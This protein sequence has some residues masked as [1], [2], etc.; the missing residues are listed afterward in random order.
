MYYYEHDSFFFGNYARSDHPTRCMSSQARTQEGK[1]G[2]FRRLPARMVTDV[3]SLETS[4]MWMELRG[5]IDIPVF[6]LAPDP[7]MCRDHV[8]HGVQRMKNPASAV[9]HE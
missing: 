7:N 8:E 2:H 6:E 3:T 5:Q 9:F 1:C 4:T